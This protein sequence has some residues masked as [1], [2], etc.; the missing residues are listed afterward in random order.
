MIPSCTNLLPKTTIDLLLMLLGHACI[1]SSLF[2]HTVIHIAAITTSGICTGLAYTFLAP[3]RSSSPALHCLQLTN[4][5]CPSSLSHQ[6]YCQHHSKASYRTRCNIKSTGQFPQERPPLPQKLVQKIVSSEYFD[7]AD[8]LPDQL[9]AW[10]CSW[11][12]ISLQ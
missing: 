3:N 12:F 10:N 4:N 8:L 5:H 11:S 6:Q 7:L 1:Y 9:L 2:R